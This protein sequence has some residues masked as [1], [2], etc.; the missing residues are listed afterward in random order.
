M[1]LPADFKGL[2]M[3]LAGKLR[4]SLGAPDENLG[5]LEEQLLRGGHEVLRQMLEQK[6]SE[7]DQ[8]MSRP[9]G[10]LQQDADLQ[11]QLAL[12]PFTL[13]IELDAWN[14]RERDD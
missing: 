4:D 13:V 8:Q 6:R 11:L 7:L 14:I 3:G 2:L 5:H 1:L 10:R 9:E 12:E